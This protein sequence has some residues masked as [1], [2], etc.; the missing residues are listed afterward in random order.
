M[1]HLA[2]QKYKE[3]MDYMN[4]YWEGWGDKQQY[5][6]PYPN[7]DEMTD[8]ELMDGLLKEHMMA[9]QPR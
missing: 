1:R 4:K 2:I 9:S 5:I 6:R 8:E 7:F 3:V